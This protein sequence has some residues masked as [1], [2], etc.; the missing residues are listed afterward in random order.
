M[1]QNS[2]PEDGIKMLANIAVVRA[3]TSC[4]SSRRI[5]PELA[6]KIYTY[7]TSTDGEQELI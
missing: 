7:F 2:S 6:R 4:S 3:T 5:G 1:L